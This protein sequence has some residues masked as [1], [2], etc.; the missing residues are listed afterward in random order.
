MDVK[1]PAVTLQSFNLNLFRAAQGATFRAPLVSDPSLEAL[2]RRIMLQ[3]VHRKKKMEKKNNPSFL[4]STPFLPALLN[5]LFPYASGS[6]G[7][8]GRD[9]PGINRDASWD[10]KFNDSSCLSNWGVKPINFC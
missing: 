9:G 10:L 5:D 8:R 4:V 2:L 1:N 3:N 6:S 7:R